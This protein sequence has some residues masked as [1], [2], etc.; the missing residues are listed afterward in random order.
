MLTT[1][2]NIN[3]L[4]SM[5]NCFVKESKRYENLT[6]LPKALFTRDISAHNITIKIKRYF[7]KKIILSH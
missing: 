5:D 1:V 4:F 7:D 3:Y 2:K 6:Y